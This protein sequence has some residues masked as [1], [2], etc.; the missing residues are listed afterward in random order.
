MRSLPVH[1]WSVLGR[2]AAK[3]PIRLDGMWN[4]IERAIWS[5]VIGLLSGILAVTFVEAI[6]TLEIFYW[7][8]DEGIILW[9]WWLVITIPAASGFVVG[10]LVQ[11]WIPGKRSH[12]VADVISASVRRGGRVSYRIG[13]PSALAAILSLAGGA[14][15]GREGPMVHLAATASSWIA[16]RFHLPAEDRKLL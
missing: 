9:P 6:K 11:L 8:N 3:I 4:E 16:K 12:G 14:S 1:I 13:I 2:L 7:G 5:S 15:T 10:L